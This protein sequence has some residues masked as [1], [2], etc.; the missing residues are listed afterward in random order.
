LADAWIAAAAL[1]CG[2]TLLHKDPEFQSIA[3]L[4]QEWLGCGGVDRFEISPP[5]GGENP[6]W[7]SH[8]GQR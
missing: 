6:D 8:Q 3:G 1:Q 4:D 2:A 5:G 7:G